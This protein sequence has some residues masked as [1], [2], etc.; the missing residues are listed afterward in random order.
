MAYAASDRERVNGKNE[1]MRISHRATAGE[2]DSS[3]SY[4][5]RDLKPNSDGDLVTDALWTAPSDE[6]KGERV[7]RFYF[8]LRD[9]R[10]GFATTERFACRP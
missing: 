4:L 8:G 9:G 2:F 3:V 7:I 10:G 1:Q 5:A 6:E